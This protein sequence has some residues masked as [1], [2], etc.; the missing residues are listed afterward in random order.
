[1]EY[2]SQ[3]IAFEQGELD[4]DG[5]IEL[6]QGLVDNGMAWALQGHYGRTAISLIEAGL[7]TKR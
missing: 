4:E 7:I 5:V 1:M 6:F 2:L 3:I